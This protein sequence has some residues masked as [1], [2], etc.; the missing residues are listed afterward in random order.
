MS[1][2]N[3]DIPRVL[4][5]SH[6]VMGGSTGMGKTLENMLSVLPNDH[7]AQLFFHS[8][9]PTQNVCD[10]YYRITDLDMLLSLG[11]K[12]TTGSIFG[13][14]DVVN[15]RS[16]RVDTGAVAKV[17][18]FGRQRTSLIYVLRNLLW[19]L[20][21]WYTPELDNWLRSF[22][23]DVIFFA[24]GDYSFAYTIVYTV[25]EKLGIPVVMWCADDYYLGHS[26][27]GAVHRNL[28]HWVK[29]LDEKLAAVI[30]IS[31]KMAKDYASIFHQPIYVMHI[32]AADNPY[33]LPFDQRK[34]LTYVGSLGVGRL[35]PLLELARE[36]YRSGVKGYDYI[37]VYTGDMNEKTLDALRSTPGIHY[38]GQIDSDEVLRV[39]GSSRFVIHV[40]SFDPHYIERTRYSLSTKIGD[41]L[42]SGAC[43]IAFGPSDIASIEYLAENAVG[44]VLI[45]PSDL[46]YFLRDDSCGTIIGQRIERSQ[47]LARRFHSAN[48]NREMLL[49]LLATARVAVGGS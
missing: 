32:A 15:R 1:D 11:G 22:A 18:Q 33:A 43:L 28:M 3:R 30:A 38:R 5:I 45:D 48:S 25:S 44:F 35:K 39:I 13:P 46:Y 40:E 24:A 26:L 10:G 4:V 8:E 9:V 12:N 20:G 41:Y 17:Y 7:V 23:P 29:R 49:E 31:D 14:S 2:A 19:R 37:D 36:A 47:S 16:S 6:N 42:A 21:R 34:G 27:K